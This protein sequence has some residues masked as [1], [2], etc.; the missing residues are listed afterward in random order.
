MREPCHYGWCEETLLGYDCHCHP[1]FGGISCS[2]VNSTVTALTTMTT[3]SPPPTPTLSTSNFQNINSTVTALTN[4]TTPSPPP[5]TPTHSTSNFQNI[6]STVTALTTM[7]TPSPPPTTPTLSTSNFQNIN[8]TVTAMTTITT[9]SPPPSTPFLSTNNVK[10][11]LIGFNECYAMV[12]GSDYRGEVSITY[13]NKTCQNWTS[14]QPHSHTR[15]PVNYSDAGLGDHNFCRN[16]D[17]EEY[18]WCY[19]MSP[20][21]RWEYCDIGTPKDECTPDSM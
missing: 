19:T 9:P 2:K 7:T 13:S 6:N 5:T 10:T 21:S 20:L 15:T 4:M 16:P 18:A 12:N 14:Q 1:G 17:G 8:S 3:P 11:S